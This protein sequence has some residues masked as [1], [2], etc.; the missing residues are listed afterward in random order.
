MVFFLLV[1]WLYIFE[2]TSSFQLGN[3][4]PFSSVDFLFNSKKEVTAFKSVGVLLSDPSF[5][6]SSC[7]ISED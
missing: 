3:S 7:T 1:V 5:Y 4:P 6:F 2:T